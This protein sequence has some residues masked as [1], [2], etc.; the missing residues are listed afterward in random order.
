MCMPKA[1]QD[2]SLFLGVSL[3]TITHNHSNTFCFETEQLYMCTQIELK[4]P[5]WLLR[6]SHYYVINLAHVGEP[7]EIGIAPGGAIM[8]AHIQT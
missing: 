3:L 7:Y 5:F 1:N 6:R 8:T 4:E 2:L